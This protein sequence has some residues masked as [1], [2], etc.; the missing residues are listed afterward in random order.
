MEVLMSIR[1]IKRKLNFENRII[2]F[3][4]FPG[5]KAVFHIKDKKASKFFKQWREKK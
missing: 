5:C 4:V 3:T 1:K 2:S